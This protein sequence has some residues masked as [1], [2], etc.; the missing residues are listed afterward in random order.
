MKK[1]IF[2]ITLFAAFALQSCKK[3]FLNLETNPNTPSVAT[4]QFLLSGAE[5]TTAD[6]MNGA[7]GSY[8]AT[9][10]VWMGYTSPSGNF[11]PNTVLVSYGFGTDDYQVFTPLYQNL[12]NYDALEKLA[13]SDPSLAYFQ[14]ISKVMKAYAFQA[15]V[16]NYN[17]VPYT[18]AFQ[19]AKN[20][21]PKYDKGEA[22]YDDLM[23]QLDAAIDLI[24]KNA[25]AT[26]PGAADVIFK[27]N[28][29]SWKKFANTLKLR[30]VLRQT[31]LTAKQAAL[32]TALLTTSSEGYLDETLRAAVNP[33]FLNSDATG[34]QQSSFYRG[35]GFDQ[36]GNAQGNNT[37]YRANTYGVTKLKS[38][39]DPRLGYFYAT[40]P[41]GTYT[42]QIR[43]N[44][45]GDLQSLQNAN[46]SAIGPGLL[47]SATQDAIL[48][49][50][51]E[52]LFLQ[53]E[54]VVRGILTGDA[55]SLYQKGIT[56]SFVNL[57]LNAPA[58]IKSTDPVL[59]YSSANAA[60]LAATYYNQAIVNVGWDSSPDKIEAIINQKWTAINGYSNLESYNE[61]RR[62][63]FPLDVPRS[64]ASG[65]LGTTLPS[66]IAYPT[67]E[68]QQNAA[69]VKA[70]GTIDRFTSKIFWAK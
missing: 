24:N 31:N 29:T 28:M 7:L 9:Y 43:G 8:F 57:A 41:T 27:G 46:T 15:L 23:K 44:A 55:K 40:I 20:I 5:K 37:Y 42:G 66:R 19:A 22:I 67:S 59:P 3:D 12:T 25:S 45:F 65:A 13:V 64:V 32:K 48:F 30:I 35:Y 18:D 11:V 60:T 1:K 54:A 61:Y 4:P 38:T 62:T 47:K 51:A 2:I 33:G 36:N 69:V 17:N 16:D 56:I 39:N 34:G 63:G 50:S 53:S 21:T 58:P 49:S 6:I 68:Y 14:A 26:N 52:A 10:G 70:E